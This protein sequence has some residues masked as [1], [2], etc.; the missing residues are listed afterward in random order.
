LI[1]AKLGT[2]QIDQLGLLGVQ[3]IFTGSELDKLQTIGDAIVVVHSE[4]F[5]CRV[6]YF[7]AYPLQKR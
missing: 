6:A 4:L 5:I 3:V 7:H 2:M 1:Q